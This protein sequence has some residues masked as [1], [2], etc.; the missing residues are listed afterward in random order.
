MV[1]ELR[2]GIMTIGIS[3]FLPITL[4]SLTTIA[5]AAHVEWSKSYE[6]GHSWGWDK[7]I[8][9]ETESGYIL[10]GSK[11]FGGFSDIILIKVDRKGNEIWDRSY[12]GK[13]GEFLAS[14][15]QTPD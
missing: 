4:V 5:T 11:G 9:K 12:D 1:R 6:I 2:S 3:V 7:F 15:Q 10:A 13:C 14:I 8:V